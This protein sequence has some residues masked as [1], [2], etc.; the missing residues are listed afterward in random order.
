MLLMEQK[1]WLV[2]PT[3]IFIFWYL[4]KQCL[5]FSPNKYE[6]SQFEHGKVIQCLG[7]SAITFTS[8]ACK[9]P[10]TICSCPFIFHLEAYFFKKACVW[11]YK[12]SNIY[13][14]LSVCMYVCLFV[15]AYLCQLCVYGLIVYRRG[16]GL[17]GMVH[18]FC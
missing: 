9:S 8:L 7:Y 17:I 6:P 14:S 15:E 12:L 5:P 16:S 10:L 11:I 18:W 13:W 2:I 1:H 4:N 3:T